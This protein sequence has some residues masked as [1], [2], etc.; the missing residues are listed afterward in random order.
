MLCYQKEGTRLRSLL[1]MSRRHLSAIS[2]RIIL[3]VESVSVIGTCTSS[4]RLHSR[5]TTRRPVGRNGFRVE[6]D[7]LHGSVP[8]SVYSGSRQALQ[9]D[10]TKRSSDTSQKAE[11]GIP[12]SPVRT[13]SSRREAVFSHLRMGSSANKYKIRAL[14]LMPSSVLFQKW[15]KLFFRPY[16]HKGAMYVLRPKIMNGITG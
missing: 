6:M 16:D 10:Q 14:P 5:S 4:K 7:A 2:G 12:V 13:R 1:R 11:E 3:S 15:L 9:F 8:L